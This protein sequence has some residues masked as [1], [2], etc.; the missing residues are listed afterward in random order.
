MLRETKVPQA[1]YIELGN[2]QNPYDQLRLVL[3]KNRQ[4][5][6]NWIFDAISQ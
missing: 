2:I 1:V 4:A 6:A 3:P 5:L